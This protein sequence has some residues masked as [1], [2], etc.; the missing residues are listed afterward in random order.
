MSV[1]YAK[2]S[3]AIAIEEWSGHVPMEFPAR[4]YFIS[5]FILRNPIIITTYHHLN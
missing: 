2:V 4:S 3:Y 1:K 5:E